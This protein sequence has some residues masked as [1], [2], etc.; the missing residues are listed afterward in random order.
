MGPVATRLAPVER[1]DA[2]H[3]LGRQL[4]GEQREVRFLSL[5]PEK[6]AAK[7]VTDDAAVEAIILTGAG[8]TFVAGADGVADTNIARGLLKLT[9]G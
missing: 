5:S 8:R 9:I 1:V 3:L 2:G 4:E 7:A 6:Y